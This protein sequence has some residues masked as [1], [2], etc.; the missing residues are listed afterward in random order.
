MNKINQFILYFMLISLAGMVAVS[1]QKMDRPKLPADFPQDPPPAPYS[2]LKDY[3]AFDGNLDDQGQY[4]ATGTGTGIS[5]VDGISGQAVQ[6]GD[7][8]GIVIAQIDDSIATP[9]DITV[10]FWMKGAPGPVDG[11]AQGIF[12][13]ANSA[14]LWGN[15]SIFL[16]SYNDP[17][18]PNAAFMKLHFW[19][20]NV[21]ENQEQWI[22]GSEVQLKN[23]LGKWTHVA[24]TYTSASSAVSLYIDGEP[25]A[26]H[27]WVLNDGNYG[28]L[29]FNN[30]G[31]IALGTF[32]FMATPN[33]SGD[34][35]QGWAKSF[36]GALDNVR[37]YNVALSQSEVKQLFDNKQ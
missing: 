23:V 14:A 8:G 33:I 4:Q 37:I 6:I 20:D 10:A 19:N 7:G 5:Y 21:S 2:P 26:V 15:L 16:E 25:T 36:D 13:L 27:D 3:W 24:L 29:K 17:D 12:D 9:G 18:D 22:A 28:T 30:F 35:P 32:G 11:G 1:C 34:D 31:G